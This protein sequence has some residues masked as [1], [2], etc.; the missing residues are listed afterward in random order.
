VKA[1]FAAQPTAIR[2]KYFWRNSVAA[3]KWIKRE[4]SQPGVP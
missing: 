3:Y 1:Y 4:A 2:E